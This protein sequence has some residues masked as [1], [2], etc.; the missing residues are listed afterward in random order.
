MV[1]RIGTAEKATG[2]VADE[3]TEGSVSV[4][5]E[6]QKANEITGVNIKKIGR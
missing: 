2:L 1:Q 5:M 6:I 4:E 3:I